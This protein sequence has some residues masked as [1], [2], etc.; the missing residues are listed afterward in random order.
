MSVEVICV[1]HACWDLCFIVDEYPAE[2]AKIQTDILLES[3]GGPAA[4]AAWLLAQ[5]GVPTAL[6][7]AVGQDEYG[8][9][10]VEEL[11]KGGVDCR[12]VEQRADHATPVS[13]ILSNRLNGSRTICNRKVPAGSLALDRGIAAAMQPRVL[14]FDGHE[15][16]ASLEAMKFFP[17]AVTILDSGSL[18]EGTEVLAK[19]VDYLVCSER[20]ASQVT[21][22]HD[23]VGHWQRCLKQ[24]RALNNKVA[25][26][27]LGAHGVAF[28]DGSQQV[29]LPA[30]PVKPVDTTAAGDIFHGAFAYA[31]ARQTNVNEAFRLANVAGGLSVEK[32]GGRHSTPTLEAVK[33]E[34]HG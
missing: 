33:K 26:V 34:V 27:T 24:L 9:R 15:L 6:A 4:N 21:G 20:F 11:Q 29:H 25:A 14:L 1:G 12:L 7:A 3:G 13:A 23:I 17:A 5:W 30:L 2:N 19:K 18:R 32:A 16:E 22:E 31:L 28:D 8:R 10:V